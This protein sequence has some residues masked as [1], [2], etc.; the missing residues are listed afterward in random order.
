[1]L[2]KTRGGRILSASD[3]TMRFSVSSGVNSFLGNTGDASL[4]AVIFAVGRLLLLLLLLLYLYI[5]LY[6]EGISW[7]QFGHAETGLVK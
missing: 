2:S 1:M 5:L 4:P 7:V 6:L 3:T